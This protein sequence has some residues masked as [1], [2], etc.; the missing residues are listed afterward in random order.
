[1]VS[2][3]VLV[4]LGLWQGSV[5]IMAGSELHIENTSGTKGENSNVLGPFPLRTLLQ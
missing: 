1:M 4:L 5:L 2:W 3:F